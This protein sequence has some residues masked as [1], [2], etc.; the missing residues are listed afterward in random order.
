[1]ERAGNFGLERPMHLAR[2]DCNDVPGG[3]HCALEPADLFDTVAPARW[4][5]REA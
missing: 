5:R 3:K 4:H 2:F 1:M